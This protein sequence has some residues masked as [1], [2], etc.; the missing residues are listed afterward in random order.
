M[1]K[2]GEFIIMIIVYDFFSVYVVDVVGMDMVF[3]GDSF[4]MVVFGMEDILEVFLEE[5]LLYC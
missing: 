1:Y 2:R 3:V 4:V 5:M